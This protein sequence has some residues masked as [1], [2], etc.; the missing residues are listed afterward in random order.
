MQ[1]KTIDENIG[2]FQRDLH[3]VYDTCVS[4]L[5]RGYKCQFSWARALCAGEEQKSIFCWLVLGLLELGPLAFGVRWV[6]FWEG[7][8]RF[9]IYIRQ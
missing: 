5:T 6:F 3:G 1:K 2:I 9:L 8:L 4:Y 7:G